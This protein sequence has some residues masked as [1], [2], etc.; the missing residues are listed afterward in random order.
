MN[1]C[2]SDA[3]AG[4][5]IEYFSDKKCKSYKGTSSLDKANRQCRP[6]KFIGPS[7]RF[8]DIRCTAS[9]VPL[10]HVESSVQE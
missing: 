5:Y 1:T 2:Y 10:V 9:A 3:C 8:M 6:F 4:S 7:M